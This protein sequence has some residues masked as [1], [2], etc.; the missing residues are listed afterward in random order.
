M[1][2]SL[3]TSVLRPMLEISTSQI[4]RSRIM[5]KE[6]NNEEIFTVQQAEAFLLR[7]FSS[8]DFRR[9]L[10]PKS[11]AKT[12][13]VLGSGAS[14]EDITNV[15]FDH[16]G[17][18][19][20]VGINNWGLHPFVP[21][22]YSLESVPWIGDGKDFSRAMQFLDREDIR[23]RQPEIL[24]LR[25]KTA[26]EV[27]QISVLPPELKASVSFYGRVTPS[28][29]EA[30]NLGGDIKYFFSHI[31]PRYPSV[32]MDS[33]ASVVRMV[34]IGMLLGFRRIVLTGVD[35]NGS[36][37]FWEK[38]PEYLFNLTSPPP[39]N[40]QLSFA[41]ETTSSSNRPFDVI[42]MLRALDNFFRTEREGQLL[43]TSRHSALAEFLP[44]ET[45]G[46]C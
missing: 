22:M 31:A 14:I 2:R 13:Y 39:V 23:L 34:V 6:S 28:T 1:A 17:A 33:G 16:I 3:L 32:V 41:H 45:W 42:T 4:L 21:D 18:Q 11:A 43:V 44:L 37:Y 9:K 38:N 20:S 40:N 5:D 25:P 19:A 26:S 30:K 15:Q 36:P 35:L 24:I 8:R 12:F 27:H 10:G 7:H 46:R 29:R